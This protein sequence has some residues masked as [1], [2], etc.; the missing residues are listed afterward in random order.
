MYTGSDSGGRVEPCLYSM[1]GQG[2]RNNQLPLPLPS[3][4]LSGLT[5]RTLLLLEAVS[6]WT[7]TCLPEP[8]CGGWAGV[9]QNILRLLLLLLHAQHNPAPPI[10]MGAGGSSSPAY[11]A[12]Q[13]RCQ[14]Q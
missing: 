5:L 10:G 9:P 4:E 8:L 1:L 11:L 3:P 14:A 13:G 6:T 7:P 12:S 2:H